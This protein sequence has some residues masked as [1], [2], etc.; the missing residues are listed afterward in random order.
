A[1]FHVPVNPIH[2]SAMRLT[3]GPSAPNRCSG[4]G[5]S[6]LTTLLSRLIPSSGRRSGPRPPPVLPGSDIRF[7]WLSLLP[8]EIGWGAPS[9][10][11]R[12]G[13]TR[14]LVYSSAFFQRPALRG[15]QPLRLISSISTRHEERALVMPSAMVVTAFSIGGPD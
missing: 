8:T 12:P 6:L 7:C 4:N 11:R 5:F 10:A 9:N 3:T 14:A 1:G 13:L 2:P 15:R